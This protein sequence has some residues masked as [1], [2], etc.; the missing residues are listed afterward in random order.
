MAQPASSPMAGEVHEGRGERRRR[1][2]QGGRRGPFP[3]RSVR[4]GGSATGDCG[5][6]STRAGEGRGPRGA[7]GQARGRTG[8]VARAGARSTCGRGPA[9]SGV[10]WAEGARGRLRTAWNRARVCLRRA[11]GVGGRAMCMTGSVQLPRRQQVDDAPRR[12]AAG[13]RRIVSVNFSVPG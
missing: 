8:E 13:A 9:H 7:R 3:A 6:R 1:K 10:G 12:S 2:V 4:A 5:A 11:G